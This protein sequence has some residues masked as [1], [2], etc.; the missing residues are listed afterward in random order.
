MTMGQYIPVSEFAKLAGVSRQAIY[1]RL[2]S[3][4]MSTYIQVESRNGKQIKLVNTD[5]L[6]LF[7][8][9]ELNQLDSQI[10]SKNNKLID[11]LKEQLTAKDETIK[12]LLEQVS[13]LQE[14]N[15]ALSQGL[16]D[17]GKELTRLLDQQQQLQ[18]MSARQRA[19]PEEAE[20]E[21]KKKS[22]FN[23]LFGR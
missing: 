5:A 17:Q 20:P 7:K 19:L 18:A 6:S 10:D 22:L 13:S 23:R 8:S 9:N 4:D 21:S 2:Y 15:L 16:I 3:Q 11:S 1:S 12:Q 14:Q